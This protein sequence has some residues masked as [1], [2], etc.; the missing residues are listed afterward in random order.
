MRTDLHIH[1]EFPGIDVEL[2]VGIERKTH[3]LTIGVG[4][5]ADDDVGGGLHLERGRDQELRLRIIGIDV[6]SAGD[7]ER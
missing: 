1:F 3:I 5:F 6:I 4:G 2:F 7:A